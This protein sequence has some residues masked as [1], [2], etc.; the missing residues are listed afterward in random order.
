MRL[1]G[2]NIAVELY[3]HPARTNPQLL[4]QLRHVELRSYFSLFSVDKDYH[5]IKK[6]YPA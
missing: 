2:D 4:K 5:L 1:A 6:P 3:D